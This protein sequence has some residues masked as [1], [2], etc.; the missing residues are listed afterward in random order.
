LLFGLLAGCGGGGGGDDSAPVQ[1]STD[2][3]AFSAAGPSAE[4][5][6]TQTFTATFGKDVVQLAVVHSGDAIAS[7]SSVLTGRTAQITVTPATP[8][9][10][11]P[12]AFVGAVAVT[13]YTCA[14][15]TCSR[16]AAGSTATLPVSYQVSPAL[17]SVAP[18]V[19]A[20]GTTDTLS[21]S[22]A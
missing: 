7:T 22:V 20:A 19:E 11:G 13:G 6:A 5:P 2:A 8:A 15:T 14:D 3:I 1:I 12:G 10:I 9:A 17:L 18:Y 21:T 4:V 16:M